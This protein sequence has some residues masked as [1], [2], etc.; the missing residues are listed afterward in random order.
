MDPNYYRKYEC[1][2]ET[3]NLKAKTKLRCAKCELG[4]AHA[5]SLTV[6]SL[7]ISP[8]SVKT[9]NG[10]SPLGTTHTFTS[11]QLPPLLN[12]ECNG[13]F[14]M[15]INNDLYVNV[16]LAIIVKSANTILQTLI[17]QR[18]GN[19]IT[20]DMTFSGNTITV[21]CNPAAVCRWVYRGI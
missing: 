14:T 15:Y 11:A 5:D 21:T 18:V 20:V 17:Y 16:T 10:L 6:S 8:S 9:Y 1:N 3:Y 2:L 4:E 13:E 19:F 12:R 7:V